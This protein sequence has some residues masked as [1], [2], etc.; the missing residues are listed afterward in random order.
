[1]KNILLLFTLFLYTNVSLAQKTVKASEIM[2][3]IKSGKPIA[4]ENV[5]I[6]GVLDF[7]FMKDALDN[8]PK[9]KK[10]GW[11]N[12]NSTSNNTIEKYIE[13]KISFYN[14]T[15]KEDVLAYIPDEDSGY[16]FT[17]NFTEEAL[18]KNCKFE[19]KALFKYSKFEEF[20]DFS[21]AIFND[22][23][24]FKYAEFYNKVDFTTIIF[25]EVATF[26]YAKFTKYAPFNNST[27]K[28][29]ATFK[30][31][32]FK[33][34]VSFRNTKFEEDLNIKY[35]EVSGNFDITKMIVAYEIDSKYTKINGKS[36]SKYLIE[37]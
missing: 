16:T 22:D 4:L 28:D 11:F 35:M 17:A 8:L 3:T 9:K 29:T 34:G 32:K 13:V 36:F 15:F 14:C 24:T 2:N 18:F 19:R 31:T 7:T 21:G 27:F 12:W 37:E 20:T 5:V 10:S 26:K 6:E 30:Y 23:T 1:M 33:N 25:K